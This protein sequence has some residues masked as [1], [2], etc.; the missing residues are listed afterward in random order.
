MKTAAFFA[1]L[2][3]AAGMAVAQ[4]PVNAVTKGPRIAVEPAH[5]DFGQ[6]VKGKEL[7]KEFSIRN[8]GSEDL[9]IDNVSTSCGCTAALINDKDKTIKPGGSAPLRVTLRTSAAGRIAKSVLI[10]SNDPAK[11][12]YELKIEATV[13]EK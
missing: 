3:L 13:V 11:G 4:V 10:K 2:A 7:S 1:A 5:F 12:T 8:F 9:V 6:A